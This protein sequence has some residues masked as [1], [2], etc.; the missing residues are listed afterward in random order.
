MVTYQLLIICSGIALI[1]YF[2]GKTRIVKLAAA[3]QNRPNSIPSYYGAY[4]ALLFILPALLVA[5]WLTGQIIIFDRMILAGIPQ[6]IANAEEFSASVAL[7]RIHN[8]ADGVSVGDVDIWVTSA[9]AQLLS[10]ESASRISMNIA[11]I[12]L[13]FGAALFALSKIK[14]EFRARKRC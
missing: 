12:Y 6:A 5:I 14:L 13:S 4:P 1:A 7:A 8:L 3:S 11:A 10:L 2:V 9:A